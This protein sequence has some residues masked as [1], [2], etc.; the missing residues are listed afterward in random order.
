MAG[1]AEMSKLKSPEDYDHWRSQQAL[2]WQGAKDL[3]KLDAEH[4]VCLAEAK[5]ACIDL[6]GIP[7]PCQR[8]HLLCAVL[9]SVRQGIYGRIAAVLSRIELI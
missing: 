1:V 3:E 8:R 7:G 5:R 6:S 9:H 2:K 4:P